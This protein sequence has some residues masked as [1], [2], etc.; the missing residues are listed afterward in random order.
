MRFKATL[1]DLHE[2]SGV[3]THTD[4][5]PVRLMTFMPMTW[6]GLGPGL[7]FPH[8]TLYYTTPHSLPASNQEVRLS[9]VSLDPCKV[10]TRDTKS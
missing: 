9:A 8:A 4:D 1:D 3:R 7:R 5:N 2:L 6:T 10:S